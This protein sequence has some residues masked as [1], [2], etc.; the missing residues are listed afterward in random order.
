VTT[1]KKSSKNRLAELVEKLIA[2]EPYPFDGFMWAKR[3]HAFYLEELGFS[4]STLS[5]LIKDIPFVRCNK[6]LGSTVTVTGEDVKIEGGTKTFLLR[7]GEKGPHE[8]ALIMRGVWKNKTGRKVT[9]HQKKCL[10]GFAKDILKHFPCLDPVRVFVYAIDHWDDA[11]SCIRIAEEAEPGYKV[12]FK[13]FPRIP[14]ILRWYW[15]VVHAYVSH[16]QWEHKIG[17]TKAELWAAAALLQHTDPWLG[18]PG[19]TPAIEKAMDN[20]HT[21]MAAKAYAKMEAAEALEKKSYAVQLAEAAEN[22][23]I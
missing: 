21:I 15:A 11:A 12:E 14:T 4:Q 17:N 20:G 6:M 13:E 22:C 16:L 19:L 8:Y 5:G 3:P 1:A 18:H 9:E 7:L 23:K 2:E 10:W